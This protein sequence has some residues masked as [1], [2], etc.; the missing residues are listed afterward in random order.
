MNGLCE[1]KDSYGCDDFDGIGIWLS[2][3]MMNCFDCGRLIV[4]KSDIKM[5]WYYWEVNKFLSMV[6]NN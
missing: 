3:L 6:S 4:G 5:I 1:D 2:V